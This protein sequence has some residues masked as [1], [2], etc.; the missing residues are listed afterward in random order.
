[1]ID[2]NDFSEIMRIWCADGRRLMYMM[3]FALENFIKKY[4]DQ[5][6]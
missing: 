6:M 2:V 5:I 3:A 4:W 1:M